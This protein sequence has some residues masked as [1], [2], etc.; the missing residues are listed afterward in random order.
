LIR[1]FIDQTFHVTE[2]V[3]ARAHLEIYWSTRW[4]GLLNRQTR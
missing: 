4:G 2:R 3:K 1:K